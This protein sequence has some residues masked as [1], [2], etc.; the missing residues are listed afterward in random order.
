MVTVEGEEIEYQKVLDR[1]E[2]RLAER[3][4]ETLNN[5]RFIYDI[6]FG[7]VLTDIP[8]PSNQEYVTAYAE[9]FRNK[10]GRGML[11]E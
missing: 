1:M 3:V 7:W 10:Y 9:A 4:W 6:S 2:C 11:V 5:S 8:S